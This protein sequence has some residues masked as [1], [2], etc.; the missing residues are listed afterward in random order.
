MVEDSNVPK[1]LP[2]MESDYFDFVSL[3]NHS[4]VQQFSRIR[5]MSM[6]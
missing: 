5:T 2:L 1:I 3:V 4:G 6:H